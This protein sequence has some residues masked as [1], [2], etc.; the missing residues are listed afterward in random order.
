MDCEPPDHGTTKT[1]RRTITVIV[2]GR[3]KTIDDRVLTFTEVIELA[4]DDPPSGPQV[5]F[6]ITYRRGR[7]DKPEGTLVEGG[8]VRAKNRMV[9]N[10]TATDKS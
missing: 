1:N 9:F 5:M 7:G 10:V 4:F 2:N 3:E 6:S 8:Q